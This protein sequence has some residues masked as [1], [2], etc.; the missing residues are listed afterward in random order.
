VTADLNH[1]AGPGPVAN[2]STR[3]DPLAVAFDTAANR[4]VRRAVDARGGWVPMLV[5][6]PAGQRGRDAGGLTHHERAFL[7]ACYYHRLI[8]LWGGGFV[9]GER[10][11]NPHRRFALEREW[12]RT[13]RRGQVVGRVLRVRV[14]RV[15]EASLWAADQ[16]W[17]G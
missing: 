5:P 3:R 16:G 9:G 6:T 8:Y 15:G 11:R 12:G 1:R 13:E 7:Q 17:T 2:F 4:L 10:R 14:H